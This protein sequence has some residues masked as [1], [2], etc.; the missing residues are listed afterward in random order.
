MARRVVITGLG[1]ISALGVGQ[2]AH[3][4]GLR[5]GR[6]GVKP[7]T[8]IPTEGLAIQIGAEATEFEGA[9]HFTRNELALCDRVTQM[10][11]VSGREAMADARLEIAPEAAE[12]AAVV[13]GSSMG[14]MHSL[15]ENYRLVYAERRSRIHPLT[16]PKLM[17]NAPASHLSMAFGVK[18]PAFAVTTACASSNHA[19]GQAF[20]LVRG[21]M[22][23]VALT[24]GTESQL[25]YGVLKGWEG[26]R[27]MSK[28]ACRPFSKNRNGMVQGEGAATLVLETL[29]HAEAR[30]ASIWGEIVGFGMSADA[31][32]IVQPNQ[33]GAM[34][35]MRTALADAGLAP[36]A[37]D[38][39]NAHGTATAA[40]DRTECAAI[41]QVFGAHADR[42]AVSSTKAMHG[43]AIGA[44]GALEMTAV[45]MALRDGVI[46][47]TI[48]YEEPDPECDLDVVPNEAREA[49]VDA[50]LSN[51]FAFGGLNAVLAVK[52][53]RG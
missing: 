7:L 31:G 23:D 20:H 46:A 39:I 18:G 47:P 40:N 45:L 12:R 29:E 25:T 50:A 37:I 10:S 26:L 52:A 27:V 13:I 14:G 36:E 49:R 2:A 4:E 21:G 16:V 17:P 38:Y 8:R 1:V 9:D 5:T 22:A 35:A 11:L 19:I 24:G 53:W 43:H 33:D 3:F 30:G 28:D 6:S 41:R 44:A 34:R 15:D 42:L 32:D 51:S 48:N